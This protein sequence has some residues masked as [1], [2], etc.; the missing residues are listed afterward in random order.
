VSIAVSCPHCQTVLNV[1]DDMAGRRGKCPKCNQ[2]ID[3]PAA[4]TSGALIGEQESPARQAGPTIR[5]TDTIPARSTDTLAARPAGPSPSAAA[6]SSLATWTS[7]QIATTVREAIVALPLRPPAQAGSAAMV[8][9]ITRG[10]HYLLPF[11]FGGTLAYHLV[12]NGSWAA[13]APGTPGAI[14]YWVLL[15]L[16]VLLTVMSLLSHVGPPRKR[17]AAG[18]PLDRQKAP[19]IA[20]LLDMLSKRL[21]VPAV[22]LQATWDG[23]LHE[24]RGRLYIGASSLGSLTVAEFFGVVARELAVQRSPGRRLARSE[25]ARLRRLQGGLEAGESLSLV[26]KLLSGLGALGRPITWPF[27]VAVR[28]VAEAELHQAELDAD[29]IQC[30]LVGTR[31]FL[32]TIQRRRLINYAAEMARADLPFQFREKQLQ[33]NRVKTVEDNLQT[34]PPEVQ[35]SVLETPV[36]DP[37]AS[38]YHPTWSQRI[39]TAQNLALGG[40]LKCPASARLLV[41]A[42]DALCREVTWFDCS[43]RFGSAIKRRDLKK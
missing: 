26:G 18:V 28:T 14:V 29:A 31:A 17:P 4:K 41:D 6:T 38:D 39:A 20:E 35:Q 36:D 19:L 25:F 34:L 33:E 13:N 11:L 1:R 23:A 16:G 3:I 8:C 7:D 12:M 22:E 10:L 30:E 15:V 27:M 43:Q 42:F 24:D 2:P 21:E 32:T 40:V 5:A 37:H 9:R